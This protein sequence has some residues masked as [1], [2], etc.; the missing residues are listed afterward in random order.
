MAILDANQA[1]YAEY[2]CLRFART[3]ITFESHKERKNKEKASHGDLFA[4]FSH[5]F[6]QNE[7][8]DNILG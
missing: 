2:S 4:L 1:L 6:S 5:Y 7:D 8:F 3:D